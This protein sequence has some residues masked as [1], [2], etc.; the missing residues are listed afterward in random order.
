MDFHFPNDF[1]LWLRLSSL[2]LFFDIRQN[3]FLQLTS[4]FEIRAVFKNTV[5][6]I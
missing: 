6:K 4:N 2:K 1:Q 3:I 5:D